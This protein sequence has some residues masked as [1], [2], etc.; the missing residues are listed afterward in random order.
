MIMVHGE[1]F[2]RKVTK[3][4]T[5]EKKWTLAVLAAFAGVSFVGTAY[6]AE[7]TSNEQGD[8]HA[9][10]D[11]VVTAQRREKRDLDTPAT[12]TIITAKEIEKA[13]YRNVFEAIDQQIGST[14]TSYG[15]AGQDFGFS[16]GRISLRGFD[17]GTLVMVNGVPLNLKNYTSTENIPASMVERIEIVKGAAST[18]YGGEAMSGVVNIILKQ[19]KAGESE[20]KLSQ[21]VGNQFKKTEAFY[22]DDRIILDLSREWIKA[23]PH[24]NA[25]GQN[26][27]SWMDWAVGSGQKNHAGLIAKITD[28]VSLSYNF[29]ESTIRRSST[30]YGVTG[31][32]FKPTTTRTD[33]RHD[34]Y[35]HT[36]SLVYQGRDNGVRALLGYN[37]RRVDGYNYVTRQP[38]DSNTT[39]ESY[40]FDLQKTW[41]LN[42][43]AFVLGYSYN[44]EL[45]DLTVTQQSASRTGNSLY[46][47]YSKQFTPKFNFTLGL[48]GEWV[49]DPKKD[50]RVFMPQFQTNYQFDR[51][52]AWYINIGK[53]FQ[54]PAV[55]N[56]IGKRQNTSGL[57]PESG[58]TYETGVKIRRGNDT[59]KAAV[60]H[61]DMENK[62]GWAVDTVTGDSVAVN[63]GNFRNTGVEVE[64]SKRFNDMWKLTLGGSVSNPEVQDPSTADKKWVQDAGRLEGLVRI[65]YQMAKWQAD[66]NFKYL[67]DREYYAPSRRGTAQD[68]PDK[69]Q[70][71]MNIIYTAGKD[72][73]VSL[74]IYNLLNRENY[75]N[76]YGNLDLGRNYR[77]TYT[78]AF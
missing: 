26:K 47:S 50:Q 12:T 22:A 16:A 58:W 77:L 5:R 68:I 24:S 70:L 38:V 30:T 52:T 73:E 29:T 59:W 53:A 64:Y 19:P 35:R 62:L 61:M 34:D 10:A 40:I 56:T 41:K 2:T 11:T 76:R 60:Y 31:G 18:L 8:A 37:Y 33:N 14:S 28:E 78:H 49:D 74:G 3:D 67:G 75:S 51:N 66:L 13:G 32:V 42:E 6:A 25:F 65:D 69:L 72:D 9:L 15:E 17:K 7:Q 44:R 21:T 46:A 4:M 23:R 43:D 39:M 54:M 36:A 20:V 63:K 55:D 57:K 27:V 71:N 48:R 1:H 45:A